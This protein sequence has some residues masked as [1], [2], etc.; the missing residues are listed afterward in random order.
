MAARNWS[1][2][3]NAAWPRH[4]RQVVEAYSQIGQHFPLF[5]ADQALRAGVYIDN[6]AKDLFEAGINE[7]RRRHALDTIRLCT[8]RP[9]DLLNLIEQKPREDEA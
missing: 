2:W 9:E 4:K 3:F 5:L 8:A 7:G 6:N 1:R